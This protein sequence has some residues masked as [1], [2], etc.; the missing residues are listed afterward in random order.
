MW[1][2]T[3]FSSNSSAILAKKLLIEDIASCCVIF[4]FAVCIKPSNDLPASSIALKIAS[5]RYPLEVLAPCKFLSGVLLADVLLPV[6]STKGE[7]LS[8]VL[9][10][11][12]LQ[13]GALLAAVLLPDISITE[14]LLPGIFLHGELL[15]GA[16]LGGELL[17][18][19]SSNS[20]IIKPGISSSSE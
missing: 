19:I 16:L 20:V 10:A 11:D 17:P 7:F 5:S 6:M 14:D 9:L 18:G 12:V 4:L 8:G 3:W 13:T 1:D 15:P 2:G